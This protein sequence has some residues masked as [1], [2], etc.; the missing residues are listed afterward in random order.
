MNANEAKAV[1]KLIAFIV[2]M[3]A[4]AVT[5]LIVFTPSPADMAAIAE[6]EGYAAAKEEIPYQLCPYAYDSPMSGHW[7]KGYSKWLLEAKNNPFLPLSEAEDSEFY[8]FDD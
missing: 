5:P 2:V 7:R 1:L 6:S 8:F 4:I 3:L